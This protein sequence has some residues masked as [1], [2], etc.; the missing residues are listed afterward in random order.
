MIRIPLQGAPRR[1]H[2]RSTGRIEATL[3]RQTAMALLLAAPLI[4]HAQASPFETGATALQNNLF[5]IM[6]PIAVILV[7]ALGIAAMV[8]RISWSWAVAAIAGVAMTFGAPQIVTWIRG[9]FGV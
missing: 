2:N 7:I 1:T 5:T 4:A 9:A 8:N 3:L 6:T